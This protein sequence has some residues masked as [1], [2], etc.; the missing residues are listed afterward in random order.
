[1]G[2]A[3]ISSKP[4]GENSPYPV[5]F[6]AQKHGLTAKASGVIIRANGPSRRACDIAAVAFI[7]AVARRNRQSQR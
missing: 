3:R 1:M 4:A 7:A 5:E 6:F 2:K